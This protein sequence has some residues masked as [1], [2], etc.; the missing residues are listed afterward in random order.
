MILLFTTD[1][2]FFFDS[3][4]E[5]TAKIRPFVVSAVLRD[6]TF[7]AESYA[8]FIDLQDKLHQNV[9]RKR[10]LVAIGTHDMD[11][12]QGP[13]TYDA[14][15]PKDIK[16]KPLNQTKEFTGPELMEF[17]SVNVNP[18][19]AFPLCAVFPLILVYI[20]FEVY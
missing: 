10:T 7:T 4:F 8:S 6:V 19:I 11:T 3:C 5:Q 2:H 17:Y 9:A 1:L 13:F 18:C 20:P 16:F 14:L 12:I 15:P